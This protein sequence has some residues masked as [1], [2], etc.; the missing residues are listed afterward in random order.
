MRSIREGTQN[1]MKLNNPHITC[2]DG[3]TISVQASEYRHSK[4]RTGVGPFT[5][6]ECGYPTA[7]PTPALL[8]YAEDPEDPLQTVYSFVPIAVVEEFLAAHGGIKEGEM[9]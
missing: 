8:K 2:L 3:T 1:F 5:E 9:P 7:E 4:P 6:V